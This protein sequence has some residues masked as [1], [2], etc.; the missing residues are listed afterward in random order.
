[1]G[2]KIAD[3]KRETNCEQLHDLRAK[4]YKTATAE[5]MRTYTPYTHT[6]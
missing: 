1:M 6:C 5:K 2:Q 3:G 4:T